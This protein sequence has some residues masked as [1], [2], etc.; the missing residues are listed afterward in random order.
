MDVKCPKCGLIADSIR[1]SSG[2]TVLGGAVGEA[3]KLC[4]MRDTGLKRPAS[5]TWWREEAHKVT[6][7]PIG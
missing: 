3:I 1:S 4:Q 5:C 2:W 7:R 6:G